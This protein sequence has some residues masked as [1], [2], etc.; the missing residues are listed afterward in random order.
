[1]DFVCSGEAD[2]TF[3]ELIKR[4]AYRHPIDDLPGIVHRRNG[5]SHA[6]APAPMTTRLDRLPI[7]DFSDYFSR[8]RQMPL[9]PGA[10]PCV[11]IETS[12]GCWW[13]EKNHCTFCG[14]NSQSM[15]YRSKSAERSIAE[16]EQLQRAVQ[17][18]L[19]AGRRQHPEP[20][21]LRRLSAGSREPAAR[22]HHLLRG[23]GQSAQAAGRS[24]EGRRV[25]VVQAGIESLSTHT[26]KLMRKGST[27]LMNV[28][29]SEM[30][31]GIR[32]AVRLEPDLRISGRR[33]RGLSPLGRAR[34]RC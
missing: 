20:S 22:G 32:R 1:M 15:E 31:Q 11:L 17:G 30:V 28:Q 14:L 34:P 9:P 4:L 8:V 33:S 3:P 13:G 23:Q 21:V 2:D 16:V 6:T 5:V 19:C 29:T 7:P 10:D 25:T 12:R 24:A 27:S 18:Q 26:L